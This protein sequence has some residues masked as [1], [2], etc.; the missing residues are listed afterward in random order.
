MSFARAALNGSIWSLGQ[1]LIERGLQA[2]L[3]FIVAKL[4]GPAEFGIAAIA[5]S[6]P[7]VF[8]ATMAGVVQI[9]IQRR[10]L[11][12][13][14]LLSAFWLAMVIGGSFTILTLLVAPLVAHLV[15]V[16]DIT[17]Y[18]SLAAFAP[19]ISA[20]G[21]VGEGI[22]THR[23]EFKLL[24]LRRTIGL[25]GAAP[26]CI[27][28]AFAG[29]GPWSLIANTLLTSLISAIVALRGSNFRP[30]LHIDREELRT[31]SRS[32]FYTCFAQASIGA[33]TRLVDLLIG[34]VAGPAMAGNFRLARTVIDLV[35]SVTY[36][37]VT[38]ILL[39]VMARV[40]ADPVRSSAAF[41][42]VIFVSGIIL[43]LPAIGLFASAEGFAIHLIG[44]EWAAAG[45]LLAWMA[46]AYPAAA[47]ISPAQAFST[48][49]GLFRLGLWITLLDLALNIVF[50]GVGATQG[51]AVLGA[52]FSLRAAIAAGFILYLVLRADEE[53][54]WPA[55]RKA[56]RPIWI[57]CLVIPPIWAIRD[58]ANYSGLWGVIALGAGALVVYAALVMLLCR[59]AWVDTLSAFPIPAPLRRIA[60]RLL[61]ADHSD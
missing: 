21:S 52:M 48:A 61:R 49:K 58:L 6:L 41:T 36:Q 27:L 53:L 15:S 33:N 54:R 51:P 12:E 28:L 13:G 39:P 18:M 43:S 5:I 40:T 20:L 30:K 16:P 44:R 35:L 50:L 22:L 14:F 10:V 42:R 2:A 8:V 57:T 46:L 17:L 24:A 7:M 47:L 25:L 11:S 38:N 32:A 9:V 26:V 1:M 37:P 55:I 23:F 34:I 60:N 31:I 19:L 29:Y 59:N 45:P 56:L 4:L 3:F